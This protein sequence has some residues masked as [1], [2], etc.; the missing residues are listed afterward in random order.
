MASFKEIKANTIYRVTSK[1][2]RLW[3][4]YANGYYMTL[5][6]MEAVLTPNSYSRKVWEKD[7][8][9]N[10]IRDEDGKKVPV[11]DENGRQEINFVYDQGGWRETA[12]KKG[13]IWM[14]YIG[15]AQIK[16]VGVY[17]TQT[18]EID[19]DYW[20]DPDV[21]EYTEKQVC[22]GERLNREVGERPEID[23]TDLHLVQTKHVGY[24]G[25][26]SV[27]ELFARSD[28]IYLENQ[29]EKASAQLAQVTNKRKVSELSEDTWD[30]FLNAK[31]EKLFDIEKYRGESNRKQYTKGKAHD[32]DSRYDYRPRISYG[33]LYAVDKLIN[34]LQD[35]RENVQYYRK[36]W[37]EAKQGE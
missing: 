27:E 37:Q 1:S 31:G 35:A 32:D 8:D 6:A 26:D 28:E 5:D 12:P 24:V 33:T 18:V 9:G 17:E 13:S 19:S 15:D 14:I 22:I 11:L 23:P 10:E 7:E 30:L 29:A 16:T 20:D 3:S 21:P 2:S 25:W 4:N 34:E 36:L